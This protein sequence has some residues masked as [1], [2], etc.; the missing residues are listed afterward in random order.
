MP[1]I[2]S[3]VSTKVGQGVVVYNDLLKRKVTVRFE[4]ED[5]NKKDEVFELDDG[6][7]DKNGGYERS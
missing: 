3:T 7:F 2:N 1:R 4:D 6:K 5:G